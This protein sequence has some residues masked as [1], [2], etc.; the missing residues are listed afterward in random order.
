MRGTRRGRR[1]NLK[2]TLSGRLNL[3]SL[4][5][6][7]A[8][9]LLFVLKCYLVGGESYTPPPGVQLPNSTAESP[10]PTSIT[11]AIDKDAISVGSEKVASVADA[12]ASDQMTIAPLDA[13]LQ[14]VWKQL[15]EISAKSGKG[16]AESQVVTI[17]GDKDIQFRVLQK[18]MYT[19][20]RN[21]FEDIA[22]AVARNS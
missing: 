14:E 4:M 7:L 6:I 16:R 11:I 10:V 2:A 13:R 15:D 22:L 8:T 3:T 20:H 5:D 12:M 19:L 21:G 9:L 17:E 18:V 1:I